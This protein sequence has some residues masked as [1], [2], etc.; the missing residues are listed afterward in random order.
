[1]EIFYLINRVCKV[2]LILMDFV[3][4]SEEMIVLRI[5]DFEDV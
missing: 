4:D 5:V 3:E 2:K 1:M